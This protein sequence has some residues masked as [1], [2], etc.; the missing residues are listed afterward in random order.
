MKSRLENLQ[1]FATTKDTGGTNSL[2]ARIGDSLRNQIQQTQLRNLK[3]VGRQT[4]LDSRET[5]DSVYNQRN[6]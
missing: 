6:A 1:S 2:A 5:F 4:E 3:Q